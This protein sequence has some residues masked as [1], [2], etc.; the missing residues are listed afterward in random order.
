MMTDYLTSSCN[1]TAQHRLLGARGG[2]AQVTYTR[3][4][5]FGSDV[6]VTLKETLDLRAGI[7]GASERALR[8]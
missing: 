4:G 6:S 8:V 5:S 3:N 7:R 1:Q 2:G